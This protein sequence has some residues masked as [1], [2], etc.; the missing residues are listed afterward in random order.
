MKPPD[1]DW[2][3]MKGTVGSTPMDCLIP[4]G[5]TSENVVK[6]MACSDAPWMP[7]P[8][9]PIKRPPERRPRASFDQKLFP[10]EP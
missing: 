1:V 7:L 6:P 9:P 5:V 2:D 8:S 4:M 3:V 10:S